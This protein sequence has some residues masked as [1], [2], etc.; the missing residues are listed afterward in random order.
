MSR[1]IASADVSL[2]AKIFAEHCTDCHGLS[3]RGDGKLVK[4]GQI[5]APRDFT[6]PATVEN[7]PI[8][9]WLET[10][11][12]GR[13]EKLM[14]PWG[15]S[16][17]TEELAA[18]AVYTYKLSSGGTETASAQQPVSTEE[19]VVTTENA[20]A[21]EVAE[22]PGVVHGTI[23]NGTAGAVVSGEMTV[24]LYVL[25]SS[26]NQVD[27]LTQ[28]VSGADVTFNDVPMRPE[29][30]CAMTVLYQDTWF[31]SDPLPCTPDNPNL[32]L[33]VTIYDKTS[34][35]SAVEIT[36]LLTQV[37]RQGSQLFV[38][39]IVSFD[40]VTD[41]AYSS[42]TPLDETHYASV[43]VTLPPGA[44]AHLT[45]TE[46][47]TLSLDGRTV[48]DTVPVL[49]GQPHTMH[50]SYFLPFN[51]SAVIEIPVTYRMNNQA[52]V[53]LPPGQFSVSSAQFRST[54]TQQFA[55]GQYDDYVAEPVEPGQSLRLELNTNTTVFTGNNNMPLAIGLSLAGIG[56]MVF[57]AVLYWSQRRQPVAVPAGA[58]PSLQ[59]QIDALVQQIGD[60]D[61]RHGQ[62]VI[63]E[64]S[65]KQ[66][67]TALKKRLSMLM[68]QS[69]NS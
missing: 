69:K 17:S 2:G 35:P 20:P 58:A 63:K 49:P 9:N 22:T 41:K 12:A 1:F 36:L 21:P 8:E 14:P 25:D 7:I 62:G 57:S 6:N 65:Y 16:L 27:L 19:A 64:K 48:M 3:G 28:T 30:N 55:S 66:Q 23:T 53:M 56:L 31:S 24:R 38:L 29:Q 68:E 18:V 54:G 50:V 34:D 33:S 47:Y 42:A 51:G 46:G 44:Q 52:E 11:R 43:G 37:Q 39:Q 59:S 32:E 45:G 4:S 61:I 13:I 5:Q 67:R 26:F 10:I 40:N 15:N 60:L